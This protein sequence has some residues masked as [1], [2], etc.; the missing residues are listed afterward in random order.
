MAITSLDALHG[1]P[2]DGSDELPFMFDVVKRY[3][4]HLADGTSDAHPDG[5]RFMP[6][7][8]YVDPAVHQA[9]VAMLRR[10][11]LVAAH[12]SQLPA[13][14]TFATEEL[15]GTPILLVRQKDGTVSAFLN[16]CI[17]RGAK[18]AEG[19]GK[20]KPRFVCPYH[21]W[22]Y[23]T[24]GTLA[25]VADETKFGTFDKDCHS[26]ISIPCTERYGLIFVT[27]DPDGQT[28]VDAFLGDFAPILARMRLGEFEMYGQWP[29]PH[30]MNWKIALSTYY[31]SYHIKTVHAGTIAPVFVGNLSTHDSYGPDGQHLVTT[32]A[33]QSMNEFVGLGDDEV[34]ERLVA[35]APYTK[36]LFLF[37]NVVITG[38]D[39]GKSF[40]H[41]IRITP[42]AGPGEQLTDFRMVKR[43]GLPP[44]TETFIEEFAKVTLYA[45]EEEDYKTVTHTATALATGLQKGIHFGANEITLTELH[46]NWA[47]AAGRPL[48]DTAVAR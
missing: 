39:A 32:W 21:A 3:Q 6:A 36:V 17:H 14:S 19:S 16:S 24:D 20:A 34:R 22:S 42:G 46:R 7:S 25:G 13:S 45:L 12:S 10:T 48:P 26:L 4:R 35:G 11:P 27:L 1:A 18:L 38:D 9:D 31:E 28:D 40:S 44:E 5:P 8:E 23:R 41:L 15:L 29:E 37:P 30:P 43:P 33:M 2:T 47:R